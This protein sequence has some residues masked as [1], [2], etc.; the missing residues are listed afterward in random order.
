M[1]GGDAMQQTVRLGSAATRRTASVGLVVLATYVSIV[2]AAPTARAWDEA[3]AVAIQLLLPAALAS[4]VLLCIACR[5]YPRAGVAWYAA[6]TTMVGVQGFP[7]LVVPSG[8]SGLAEPVMLWSAAALGAAMLVLVKFAAAPRV[9]VAP[10]S[11]GVGL[12]LALILLRGV[13]EL[14]PG[15]LVVSTRTTAFGCALLVAVSAALAVAVWQHSA[16][17]SASRRLLAVAV[18]LWSASIS[19]HGLT[20]T[21]TPA[22]S[23]VAI[24]GAL[25]TCALVMSTSLELLW[26]ALR[27]DR[28][29]VLQL[30]QQMITLRARAKEGVEQLHEVKGTIAGI[31]S[32]TDL[33]RHEE[34]LTPKHREHLAEMLAHETARLQRLVHAGPKHSMQVVDLDEILQ[35]LLTSRE[36]QGQQIGWDACGLQ[37]VA[38]ADELTEVL[39]ILLH[40][41]AEHAPG[42]PVQVFT[43]SHDGLLELVVADCGP[44]VPEELRDRIFEWG[45]SRPGSIGQGVGLAMAHQLLA[46]RGI[47][48][49][50]DPEHTAGAAFVMQ[51]RP[52][53]Q[54][55]PQREAA[56]LVR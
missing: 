32:A 48:L 28:E 9:E 5:L 52:A 46:A 38:D 17:P 35:P 39:N 15:T 36:V 30:Q 7:S 49:A 24:V 47:T 31:A 56:L 3:T 16:L 50:L 27:D 14:V 54:Q 29:A 43:R 25:F 44:G 34:R 41:A 42:A 37:V 26:Q 22:W 10:V 6:A 21:D 33:I 51:L 45:Y 2:V 40:N 53:E 1:T 23:V 4:A 8:S 12:G 13:G 18:V 20:L 11:I 55:S 19:L